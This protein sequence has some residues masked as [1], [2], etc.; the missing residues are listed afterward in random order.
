MKKQGL[1]QSVTYS[2]ASPPPPANQPISQSA[3][4]GWEQKEGSSEKTVHFL[5]TARIGLSCKNPSFI[6]ITGGIGRLR[7]GAS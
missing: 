3:G 1:R 2:R 7:P 5:S 4:F 6:Q